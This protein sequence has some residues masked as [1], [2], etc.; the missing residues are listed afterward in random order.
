MQE[1]AGNF[2]AIDPGSSL[3]GYGK[4]VF[5]HLPNTGDCGRVREFLTDVFRKVSKEL[6]L[7]YGM[8]Q[9]HYAWNLSRENVQLRRGQG[10][11]AE[12]ELVN[13]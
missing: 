6:H 13:Y 4:I 5:G 2:V 7:I 3:L 11:A 8:A 10:V 1:S 12:S 9:H